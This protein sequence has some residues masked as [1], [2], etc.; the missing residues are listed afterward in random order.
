[1]FS[2]IISPSDKKSKPETKNVF[3]ASESLPPADPR[4][5]QIRYL[6]FQPAPDGPGTRPGGQVWKFS[7]GQGFFSSL[8]LLLP[9]LLLLAF[10]PDR[11]KSQIQTGVLHST[12]VLF[13]RVG[14]TA[15]VAPTRFCAT[16]TRY[17]VLLFL[18]VGVGSAT[19]P[20]YKIPMQ[21]NCIGILSIFLLMQ[22]RY[23]RKRI[24]YIC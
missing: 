21:K 11:R 12:P 7:S 17:L 20:T 5:L 3:K 6:L 24:R 23:I 9:F 10:F 1:M 18:L 19:R 8:L 4:H 13:S 15:R 16:R 14:A 2:Y 22:N